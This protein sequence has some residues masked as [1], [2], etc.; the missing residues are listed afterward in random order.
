MT[1]T[2]ES[3]NAA[4]RAARALALEACRTLPASDVFVAL[5]CE[6]AILAHAMGGEAHFMASAQTCFRMVGGDFVNAGA[7]F[8]SAL[9]VAKV[10]ARQGAQ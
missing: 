8:E 9:A 7:Q 3:S 10:R 5:L 4:A 2:P 1:P 6:A